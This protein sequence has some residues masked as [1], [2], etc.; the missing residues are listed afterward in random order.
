MFES[1]SLDVDA[2]NNQVCAVS[3]QIREAAEFNEN[4]ES[5]WSL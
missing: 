5:L 4:R 3:T 1:A 2:L